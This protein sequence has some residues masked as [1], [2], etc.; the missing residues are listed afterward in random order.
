M[1]HWRL[2]WFNT[3]EIILKCTEKEVK[4]DTYTWYLPHQ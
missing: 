4:G 2:S 1:C 3:D